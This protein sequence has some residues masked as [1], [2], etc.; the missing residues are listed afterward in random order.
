M[1][2]RETLLCRCPMCLDGAKRSPSRRLLRGGRSTGS[3]D[4]KAFDNRRC[5]EVLAT[6]LLAECLPVMLH[7]GSKAQTVGRAATLVRSLYCHAR[8]YSKNTHALRIMAAL[9]KAGCAPLCRDGPISWPIIAVPFHAAT[10]KCTRSN[11][12]C[13]SISLGISY[14]L[15]PV[16]TRHGDAAL[17]FRSRFGSPFLHLLFV[18][19][20]CPPSNILVRLVCARQQKTLSGDAFDF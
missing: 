16:V 12:T 9:F 15:P 13:N 4:S 14:R 19:S 2:K 5:E 18:Y 3:F 10:C 17:R 11:P 1:S 6:H 7:S 20:G 8:L